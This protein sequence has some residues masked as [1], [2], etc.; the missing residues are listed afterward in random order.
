MKKEKNLSLAE[1]R[2]SP[3]FED[4]TVWNDDLQVG[5]RG[6]DELVFGPNWVGVDSVTIFE[7]LLRHPGSYLHL[8][9]RGFKNLKNA[10]T[11]VTVE[12]EAIEYKDACLVFHYLNIVLH[13]L[14]H[15]RDW[16]WDFILAIPKVVDQRF[17][18]IQSAAGRGAKARWVSPC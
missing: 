12:A 6:H 8:D 10:A 4:A 17:R 16:G 9:L 14:R 13:R 7:E 11:K 2:E 15:Y 18:E 1:L 5:I 3:S